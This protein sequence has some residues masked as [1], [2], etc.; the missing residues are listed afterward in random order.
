MKTIKKEL[1]AVQIQIKEALTI[2]CRGYY[3]KLYLLQEILEIQ[4]N[5]DILIKDAQVEFLELQFEK[6]YNITLKEAYKKQ[7]PVNFI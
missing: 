5:I 2:S 4:E 3:N 6:K 1:K 7:Q